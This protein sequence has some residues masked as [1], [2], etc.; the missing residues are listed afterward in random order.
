MGPELTQRAV[1]E[2]L[3]PDRVSSVGAFQAALPRLKE[4]LWDIESPR[5][6]VNDTQGTIAPRGLLP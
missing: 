2:R 6:P 1:A 5:H 3:T 4:Q